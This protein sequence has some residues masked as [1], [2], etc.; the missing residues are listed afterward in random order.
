MY[1]LLYEYVDLYMFVRLKSYDPR[2]WQ[3]SITKNEYYTQIYHG[4]DSEASSSFICISFLDVHNF[5]CV[6]SIHD[7]VYVFM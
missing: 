4:S 1:I 2:F 3:T 6:L 7:F 5:I